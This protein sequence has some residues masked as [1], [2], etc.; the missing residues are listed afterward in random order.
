MK[1]RRGL[2]LV[3]V[4]FAATLIGLIIMVMMSILPSAMLGVRKVEHRTKAG[5]LAQ[6]LLEEKRAGPFSSLDIPPAQTRIT[7]SDGT[8]Y[9]ISYVTLTRPSS[10]PAR[11]K[12]MRIV[13]SWSEREITQS[14]MRELWLCNIP[15]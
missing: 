4:I 13:V 12:G 10:D 5:S 11:L 9:D 1:H 7:D 2:S 15:R 6:S 3:E 14:V 8:V